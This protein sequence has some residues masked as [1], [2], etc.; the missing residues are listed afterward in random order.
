MR[1]LWRDTPVETLT[2][3]DQDVRTLIEPPALS[4]VT[5]DGK[6]DRVWLGAYTKDT[7]LAVENVFLLQLPGLVPDSAAATNYSPDGQVSRCFRTASGIRGASWRT[8][9]A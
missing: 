1:P 5:P 6:V 2:A 7:L 3:L 8:L 9:H 4:V